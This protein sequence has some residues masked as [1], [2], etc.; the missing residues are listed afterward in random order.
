MKLEELK[1]EH[2]PKAIGPYSHGRKYGNMII[3]SGQIPL[4]P[5]TN[6]MVT[7]IKAAT[8]TV[9]NNLL[10]I[11]EAG[12]GCK[13]SIAK[14]DVFVKTLDDFAAINEVYTEFFGE[15]RPARVL[16][17]VGDLPAGAKLEAAMTAFVCD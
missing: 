10:S 5:D 16:V 15:H 17:Q 1:S 14:V 11:V 9:L 7:E 6:E 4:D 13:E 12:G 2:A 3:T 8:R